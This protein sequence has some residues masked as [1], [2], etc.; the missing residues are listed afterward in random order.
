MTTDD[1][2]D[3]LIL[4]RTPDFPASRLREALVASR[5]AGV[6]LDVLRKRSLGL[7]DEARAWL[8]NPDEAMLARDLAWLAEPGHR[9]LRCTDEDFPP[10]L[11]SIAQPPAALFVVGDASLL[12]RPQ[13][14]IVGSRAAAAPALANARIFAD[15]LARDGLIVTSG[16]ADGVDGAAHEAALDAGM[17]TVAVVGTGPDRVYPRKHHALARRI[18]EHGVIVTEHAPGIG[19]L[20]YHFP[21][22]N[23]II[24]GLSLGV[25]VVEAGLRSGSLITARQAGEQGREVFALPGSIHNPL[26][27]GCHELIGE[28]ARLVQRPAEILEALAPAA[29][30]LGAELAARLALP[31]TQASGKRSSGPFDWRADPE[32][33]RLLDAMGYDPAPLDTLLRT[34]GFAPA[35]LSSMLIMLELEGQVASLPGNRYQRLPE[36]PAA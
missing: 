23:R 4:L 6:V 16:M 35:A 29:R 17:P 27:E 15:A 34:T 1:D 30:E 19:A 14:A 9:L 24:A 21:R 7:S 36:P 3:W 31:A 28:G 13:I 5:R 26:S 11:E 20:P 8:D 32:Y 18:A 22:R 2:R 33:R 10:Q 12:L 25:L